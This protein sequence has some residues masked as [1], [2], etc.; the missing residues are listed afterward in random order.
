M[1]GGFER[2]CQGDEVESYHWYVL[3][4]FRTRF[5]IFATRQVRVL[6]RVVWPT[7]HSLFLLSSWTYTNVFL[8]TSQVS[9][10]KDT[11]ERASS[12]PSRIPNH[13]AEN[14][15][16][17]ILE[18]GAHFYNN[19][20]GSRHLPRARKPDHF[21]V[22][23]IIALIPSFYSPP[24]SLCCFALCCP[25]HTNLSAAYMHRHRIESN[26]HFFYS[27]AWALCAVY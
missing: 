23:V 18:V 21:L 19:N 15:N 2:A 13:V 4:S 26:E 20:G 11:L 3:L 7:P 27:I 22:Y 8:F 14:E 1:A 17:L 5:P 12:K 9:H 24:V 16:T 25:S 10:R 6:G